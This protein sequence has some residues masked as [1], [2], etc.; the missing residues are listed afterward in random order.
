[1]HDMIIMYATVYLQP[2]MGNLYIVFGKYT[3]FIS[4]LIFT[5][6][7]YLIIQESS[8]LLTIQYV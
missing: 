7:I 2:T 6:N 3:T 1:M 5:S 8:N 4:L